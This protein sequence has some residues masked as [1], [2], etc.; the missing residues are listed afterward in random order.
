L[1]D[2]SDEQRTIQTIYNVVPFVLQKGWHSVEVID[3]LSAD[4]LNLDVISDH[5]EP[6]VPTF[7]DHVWGFFT[8]N[9]NK[10][11]RIT[12]IYYI[13]FLYLLYCKLLGIRQRGLQ[14]TEKMLR[15]DSV[16]TVVGELS[17]SETKSNFLTLQLP[18]NG[19][20]FC[21]TSMSITALIRKLDN[22]RKMYRYTK[23]NTINLILYN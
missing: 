18:L 1:I 19:S 14:S 6:T 11:K 3:P 20:P 17:R 16:I 12:Y 9:Y 21:I 10:T 15:E 22:H 13:V 2:R 4:I 23:C 8:G 5:F 7:I